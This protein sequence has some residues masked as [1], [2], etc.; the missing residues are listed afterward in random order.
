MQSEP[1]PREQQRH[2]P[3]HFS[4]PKYQLLNILL[5]IMITGRRFSST[6]PLIFDDSCAV[7]VDRRSHYS[8]FENTQP[9]ISFTLD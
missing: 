6:M 3:R 5:H 9:N 1:Q 8:V 4:P 2:F 7:K